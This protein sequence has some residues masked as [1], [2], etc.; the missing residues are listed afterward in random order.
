MNEPGFIFI[1]CQIGAEAAVKGEL[2]RDWPGAPIRLF[3]ARISYFQ[4]R[5]G[6]RFG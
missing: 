1:T 3:A 6:E 4:A 2:A 5:C